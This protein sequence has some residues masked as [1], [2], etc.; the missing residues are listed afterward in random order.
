MVFAFVSE[1]KRVGEAEGQR[2]N[3]QVIEFHT[4]FYFV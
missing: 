1:D 3:E 4:V 2:C